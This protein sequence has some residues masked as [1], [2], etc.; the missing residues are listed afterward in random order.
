[1]AAT[2]S[3]QRS[4]PPISMVTYWVVVLRAAPSRP[5][6]TWVSAAPMRAP[7][8]DRFWALAVLMPSRLRT[9]LTSQPVDQEFFG[10]SLLSSPVPVDWVIESPSAAM[11]VGLPD[12]DGVGVGATAAPAG[13]VA[14]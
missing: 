5:G 7:L 14:V 11:V 9:L 12:R 1:M 2:E 6:F 13:A 10:F 4:L 3:R 8:A